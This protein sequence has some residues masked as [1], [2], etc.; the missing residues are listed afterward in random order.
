MWWNAKADHAVLWAYECQGEVFGWIA[1]DS[2][3]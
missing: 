1:L 2:Q 3:D